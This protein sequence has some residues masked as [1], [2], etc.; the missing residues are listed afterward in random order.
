MGDKYEMCE[1]GRLPII[2][3]DVK[4]KWVERSCK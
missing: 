2:Q 3:I 4:K 1:V